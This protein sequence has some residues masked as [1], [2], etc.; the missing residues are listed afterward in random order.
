MQLR[1]RFTNRLVSS[2]F[3]KIRDGLGHAD[4]SYSENFTQLQ[5]TAIP[6]GWQEKSCFLVQGSPI[7][8]DLKVDH[9]GQISENTARVRIGD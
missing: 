5:T 6:L 9:W 2:E 4:V 8:S 7:W 3:S 1:L